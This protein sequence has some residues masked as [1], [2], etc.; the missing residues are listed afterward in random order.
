MSSLLSFEP[1]VDE[2]IDLFLEKLEQF[3]HSGI[4]MDFHHWLQCY[5]FDVI[6][7]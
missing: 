2:C 5:A 3:A 4:D 6:G 1:Y 7:E